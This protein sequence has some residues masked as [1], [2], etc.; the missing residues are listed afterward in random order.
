MAQPPSTPPQLQSDASG[1]VDMSPY[2]CNWVD[3]GCRCFE[4]KE[5]DKRSPTGRAET[6]IAA[7]VA[8]MGTIVPAGA[9]KP[10]LYD[11]ELRSADMEG[12][13]VNAAA[14]FPRYGN[15]EKFGKRTDV[16][17]HR[18]GVLFMFIT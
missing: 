14:R 15:L 10:A 6:H 18:Q 4:I 3:V 9:R 7:A 16:S 12:T 5:L 13:L 2:G 17:Y 8:E 1:D 11:G